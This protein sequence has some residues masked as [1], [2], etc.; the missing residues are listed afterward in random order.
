MRPGPEPGTVATK[1][2][3]HNNH[4]K[5]GGEKEGEQSPGRSL[6]ILMA[7]D[8]VRNVKN[9]YNIREG[10]GNKGIIQSFIN[11]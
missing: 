3:I 4:F 1:Q 2:N 8:C 6:F 11:V 5:V 7:S 10:R 9:V